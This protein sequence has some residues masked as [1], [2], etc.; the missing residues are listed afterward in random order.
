[1]FLSYKPDDASF[2]NHIVA[3]D[4]NTKMPFLVF[5]TLVNARGGD[6]AHAPVAEARQHQG[7]RHDD[8]WSGV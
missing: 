3:N 7:L 6:A 5:G 8:V 4:Q 1:M 2:A